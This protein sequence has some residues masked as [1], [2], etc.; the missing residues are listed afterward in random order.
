MPRRRRYGAA[1][2]DG[3]KRVA[4]FVRWKNRGGR[5]KIGFG[6][7][8][9]R[10]RV[11]AWQKN[12]VLGGPTPGVKAPGGRLASCRDDARTPNGKDSPEVLIVNSKAFLALAVAFAL[13][14][15][16]AAAD[17]AANEADDQ[18]AVA[19]GH[20]ARQ[21]WTLAVEEF[22]TLLAQFPNDSRAGEARFYLAEAWVQLR[23]FEPARQ[24]YQDYLEKAP[25]GRHAR[26]ALFRVGEAG[27]LL[28]DT[29][30][31]QRDLRRFLDA[32]PEDKFNAY[33][34][35]Y[36]G[37]LA[38]LEK[39]PAEAAQRFRQALERF[40]TGDLQDD[41]RFGLARALEQQAAT[42]RGQLALPGAGLQTRL[43]A[44]RS[45]AVRFGGV[46]V[47]TRELH[48]R[49]RRLRRLRHDVSR[50]PAARPRPL[51]PRPVVVSP[52]KTPTGRA[53]PARTRRRRRARGGGS[54]ILA[55][56]D[57][58]GPRPLEAGRRNARRRRR[59]RHGGRAGASHAVS[60]RRRAASG[61]TTPTGQPAVRRGAGP[62]ATRA[63]GG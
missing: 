33:V 48:G 52:T 25:D 51:G 16:P 26:L 58:Q 44:G 50:Q 19:A 2:A 21:R 61:Q 9:E 62:G 49:R 8:R 23:R 1:A 13:I 22:Q 27:F 55:W 14:T 40:P 53:D 46:G 31:A 41:C 34:L 43:P 60:R 56:P 38:L 42:R 45:G 32:Y 37:E 28:K 5:G 24:A 57:L 54:P 11:P 30:A 36:L 6:P 7:R 17:E 29:A 3:V 18:Y 63:L 10:R 39:Q 20:Y 12:R 59:A 47:R 4:A 15:A 35:P